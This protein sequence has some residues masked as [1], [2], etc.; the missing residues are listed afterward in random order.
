MDRVKDGSGVLQTHSFSSPILS[1]S[2]SS[3]NEPNVCAVLLS[4]VSKKLSICKWM[5][6]KERLP[7]AS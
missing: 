1:S 5:E 4:E 3:V 2:P 7:K 6:G